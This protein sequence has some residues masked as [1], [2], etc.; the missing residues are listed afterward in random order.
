MRGAK[1]Q[2][3]C[4][5]AVVQISIESDKNYD[6]CNKFLSEKNIL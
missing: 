5:G 1:C 3:S 4:K 6:W 2:N